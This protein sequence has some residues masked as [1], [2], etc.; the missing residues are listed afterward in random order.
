MARPRLPLQERFDRNYIPE[1]MSGCW[2]WTASLKK[3]NYGSFSSG[4][5]NLIAHRASWLLHYGEIPEGLRVLHRCDNPPCVNPQ[6]L[7]IGT[8]KDNTD[9][10]VAKGRLRG[11]PDFNKARREFRFCKRGHEYTPE[12]TRPRYL[13]GVFVGRQCKECKRADFRR[14]YERK[15]PCPPPLV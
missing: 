2:I 10:A 13:N 3:R 11:L 9:D 15:K 12:N 4:K 6:H 14:R 5:K 1:P 8:N 7:F